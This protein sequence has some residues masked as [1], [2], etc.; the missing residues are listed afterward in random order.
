MSN[1]KSN[2]TLVNAD[3]SPGYVAPHE[4]ACP[5]HRRYMAVHRVDGGGWGIVDRRTGRLLHEARPNQH[6][7]QGWQDVQTAVRALNGPEAR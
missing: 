6:R 3:G 2:Y 7:Y 5:D 4:S 1:S